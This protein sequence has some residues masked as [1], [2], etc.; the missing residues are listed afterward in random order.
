MK[1]DIEKINEQLNTED[2]KKVLYSLNSDIFKEDDELVT[3]HIKLN[4]ITIKVQ[5]LLL[6]MCVVRVLIFMI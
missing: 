3:P 2:V 4:Y 5:K 1:F 6:V